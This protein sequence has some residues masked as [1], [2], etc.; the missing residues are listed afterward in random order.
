MEASASWRDPHMAGLEARITGRDQRTWNGTTVRQA[1]FPRAYRLRLR[2]RGTRP[3]RPRPS[4]PEAVAS[5]VVVT[6][7]RI[8]SAYR[9]SQLTGG[10]RKRFR[11]TAPFFLL[12]GQFGLL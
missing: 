11:R 3:P 7:L 12:P 1:H 8:R 2:W 4:R 9:V 10:W 5:I 6:L